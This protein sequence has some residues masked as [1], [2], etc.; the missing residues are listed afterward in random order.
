MQ[1]V[2]GL[3]PGQGSQSVGMGHEFLASNE[4]AQELFAQADEA[5]GFSLSKLCLEGPLEELTLTQ[6]AQPAILAVSYVAFAL[7]DI[8]LAAA[9]GHSLGEYTALV[10]AGSLSFVDA[11]SLVH[12][13]GRYMQ[14]AVPAGAG[15]MLAVLGPSEEEI[16]QAISSLEENRTEIANLNSPGQTVVAGD[17]ASIDQFAAHLKEQG[18]KAIPLN[19]SAPFHCSLMQSA[20]DNLARDLDAITFADPRFPVYSNVTATAT[21]T[22]E[23]AKQLLKQQ[24]TGSVR[25]TESML[26]MIKEQDICCTVEFGS[27]SVLT[28][29]QKRI[30][31]SVPRYEISDPATM[32]STAEALAA[33]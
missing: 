8:P 17:S 28:K 1:G 27:G 30:A 3:F 7:A 12:K 31:A 23:T 4:R 20:A 15:K 33:S 25:W 11:V 21:T 22:G 19:V 6:N 26:N 24:V 32:Q 2:A 9:A 13:R 18:V 10:A 29:L 14:E 16:M 5:L